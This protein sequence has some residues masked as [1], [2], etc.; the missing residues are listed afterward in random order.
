MFLK[1]AEFACFLVTSGLGLALSGCSSGNLAP[2]SPT[3]AEA[4]YQSNPG[5]EKS[6]SGMV[7]AAVSALE[8]GNPI[9][10]T[11]TVHTA[12]EA[13]RF[14]RFRPPVDGEPQV[15]LQVSHAGGEF[16]LDSQRHSVE[17]PQV[18]SYR[19]ESVV[20]VYPPPGES[21]NYPW[22]H[23]LREWTLFDD[24]PGRTLMGYVAVSWDN[25]NP[26]DYLAGGYWVDVAGDAAQG[27]STE[28]YVGA[29]V[30]G[31]EFDPGI[32]RDAV[33]TLPETGTATYLGHASGIYTY[34]YG[35]VSAQF[36]SPEL[37]GAREMGV[38]A[39]VA[40]LNADFGRRKISGCIGCTVQG[41]GESEVIWES[42]GHIELANGHRTVISAT[43]H[44]RDGV[45]FARYYLH[46]ADIAPPGNTM[47]GMMTLENDYDLIVG[48]RGTSAGVW[49]GRF[50][51]NPDANGN[52]RLVGGTMMG[53]WTGSDG[54]NGEP[55]GPTH[56]E[57]AGFFLA[58]PK[59]GARVNFPR[60]L[61]SGE[62]VE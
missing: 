10:R 62:P 7:E 19:P 53:T 58:G 39:G 5:V 13:P 29:F 56:G 30:D 8:D 34:Y 24:S 44:N 40:Q 57:F 18:R 45:H 33:A 48:H 21:Y 27:P 54:Q 43:Y 15:R 38:W 42:D 6:I 51:L 49:E 14:E 11:A 52:P 1:K 22:S 61:P 9:P 16:T 4:R 32:Q 2:D 12:F 59:S 46:E 23:D 25:Y 35:A 17:E 47:A 36:D 60:Q 3:I 41:M 26:Y 20:L 50:S 55:G 37:I 31:P 28:A